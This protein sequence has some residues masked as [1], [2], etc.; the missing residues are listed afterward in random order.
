MTP[1]SVNID[2]YKPKK[3]KR[4]VGFRDEDDSASSHRKEDSHQ[5]SKNKD[6]SNKI[7]N[8]NKNAA[9]D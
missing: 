3:A 7:N 2:K 4:S 9:G 8:N 6:N 5:S 1:Q